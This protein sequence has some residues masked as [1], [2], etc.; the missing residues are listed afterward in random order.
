VYTTKV[1]PTINAASE[2]STIWR[3]EVMTIN[4]KISLQ[5]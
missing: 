3:H 2:T 1:I 4:N 5:Y